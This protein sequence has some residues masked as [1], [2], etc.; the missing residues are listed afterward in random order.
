LLVSL[1]K[2]LGPWELFADKFY[3][4]S[5]LLWKTALLLNQATTGKVVA[6][7]EDYP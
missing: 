3:V 6:L 5:L 4:I 1:L 2:E 7:D